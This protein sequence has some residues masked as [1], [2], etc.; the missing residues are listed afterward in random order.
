MVKCFT[1]LR[2]YMLLSNAHIGVILAAILKFFP[3]HILR[4]VQKFLV[5]FWQGMPEHILTILSCPEVIDLVGVCDGILFK[6]RIKSMWESLKAKTCRNK[7]SKCR[8]F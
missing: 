1:L 6:V 5:H 4:Q 2:T 3:S 8:R 7:D